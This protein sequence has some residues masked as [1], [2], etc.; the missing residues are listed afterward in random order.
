M[1][2]VR[3]NIL[4][5][6]NVVDVAVDNGVKKVICLSTDKAV[7]PINAMGVSKAMMEKVF[8]AKSRTSGDTKIIGTRYGN[9][10]ASRGS[11]IPLFHN[12]L[13][14]NKPLTITNPEMTR[15]MMTLENAVE[16]VLYAIE[17]GENG[18][19]FVQKAPS[20]TIGQLADVMK[21]IYKSKS[22]IKNIGV[23]HG[24]KMHETLL[25]KEE[26]LIA[27]DL[28]NY[29]KIPADNRDLNYEKYFEKGQKIDVFEE[30]NSFN[31]E[32]LSNKLLANLLASI[33]Y[34]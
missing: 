15:F 14:N 23:R 5:T 24:E 20:S 1:E 31:T 9:V 34:K 18:D 7:Y 17:N 26:R 27:E 6:S 11:V 33:G 21:D 12:Q 10:M 30:F 19:I 29:F 13:I 2:A 22:E 16:L 8:V 28:N 32:R 3:T 25:S 4:G